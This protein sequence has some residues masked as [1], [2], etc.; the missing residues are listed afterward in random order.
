MNA[1]PFPI[2][3]SCLG[4]SGV[5]QLTTYS[6]QTHHGGTGTSQVPK[7]MHLNAVDA[8]KSEVSQLASFLASSRC[9][10][11]KQLS[12]IVYVLPALVIPE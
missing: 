2:F 11:D 10:H 3:I 12:Y 9:E 8:T 1:S 7:K 5:E 4:S 6:E